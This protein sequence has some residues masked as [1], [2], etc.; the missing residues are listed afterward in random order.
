MIMIIGEKESSI[1]RQGTYIFKKPSDTNIVLPTETSL[2]QSNHPKK[3]LLD[4]WTLAHLE[5]SAYCLS[6]QGSPESLGI[7]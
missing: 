2:L 4:A 6:L 1:L 7:K 3:F 5:I